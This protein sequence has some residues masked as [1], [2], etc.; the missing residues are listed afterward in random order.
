MTS[1]IL[2]SGS[3]TRA[4]L[5]R[6][7]G[8]AFEIVSP[9]VDELLAKDS[10]HSEGA[11]P[12]AIAEH[13]AEIKARKVSLSHPGVVVIGADQVLVFENEMVSKSVDLAEAH[14]LLTRLSGRTHSLIT[15]VVLAK[16]GDVLWRHVEEAKLTM[17]KFE[18]IF[19]DSY[20]SACGDEILGSVGCYRLEEQGVQL[21]AKIDGDYF[22]ILGLPLLPLLSALR[23]LGAIAA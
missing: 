8:I 6:S 10:L 11:G 12:R 19:L 23:D 21:F 14:R 18:D 3:P 20:L 2:A 22:A 15:A 9:G 4:R 5:L 7:A 13:L 17:R 1:V 16:D